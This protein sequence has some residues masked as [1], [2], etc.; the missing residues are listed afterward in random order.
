MMIPVG[1][2]IV[3]KEEYRRPCQSP[4]DV[5][6]FIAFSCLGPLAQDKV[7]FFVALH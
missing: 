7:I 4:E 6:R 1:K 2:K 3:A 5:L